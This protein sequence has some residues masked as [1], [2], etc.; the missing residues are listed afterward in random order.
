MMGM[1]L[2]EHDTVQL[3]V[4]FTHIL[5]TFSGR[6]AGLPIDASLDGRRDQQNEK[7]R[8]KAGASI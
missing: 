4:D 2:A 7:P 1:I 6:A 8:Q 3:D 5:I